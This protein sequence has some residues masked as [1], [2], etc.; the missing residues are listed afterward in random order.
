VREK[1]GPVHTPK[2]VYFYDDLP[3]SSIGKV[4]KNAVREDVLSTL[5]SHVDA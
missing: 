2:H 1:L 5:A 4:L 3:R